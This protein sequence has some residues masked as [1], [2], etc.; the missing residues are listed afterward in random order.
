MSQA[1]TLQQ[2]LDSTSTPAANYKA[3]ADTA[4]KQ[5]RGLQSQVGTLQRPA[6][7]SGHSAA[8]SGQFGG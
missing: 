1:K 8:A 4:R 2:K 3:A 5:V 7:P 6:E